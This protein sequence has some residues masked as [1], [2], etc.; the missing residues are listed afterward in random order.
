[1]NFRLF[2]FIP[3]ICVL[4]LPVIHAG[5]Q[6]SQVAYDGQGNPIRINKD[7]ASMKLQHRDR[8]EDSITISYH[9]FDSTRNRLIDSSINDFTKK[10]TQPYYYINLGNFG[11]ASKSLLF[12]PL[13]KAGFDAGFHQYDIY[14][15]TIENTKFFQTTRP[16]TELSYLLGSKAE[17]FVDVIHTQNK[18]SNFNFSFE[19]RFSNSPGTYRTQNAS[20]NNIRFTSHYLTPNKRYEAFLIFISTKNASSENGGLKD[21][22]KLDSLSLNDPYELESRLGL[23]GTLVR[24][25]FNTTVNTGNI[26]QHNTILFRHQYD[27]GQKDSLEVDTITYRFFYP[28]LRIQHTLTINLSDYHFLDQNADSTSYSTYF[29]Y[30]IPSNDTV[31]FEDKWS[32]I[33]NEFSLI[34]FPDKK[35]ASQFAK[36]SGAF[37]NIQG[38]FAD[39]VTHKYYN[40]YLSGEYRNRSR[41]NKWDIEAFGH[42]YLNGLNAG[43]YAAGISLKGQVSKK[44]DFIQ[45]GVQN[46]NRTPS[47]IYNPVT[48]FPIIDKQNF[49]K[50][51]ISKVFANYED[52]KHGWVLSGE[53]FLVSNYTYFDSFFSAKQESTL[54][55]VLHVSAEKKFRL[56]RYFNWYTEVHL[57]QTTGNAPVHLPSFLTRNRI[58]FEGNFY[59]NL[60]LSTGFEVRYYSNY[61]ADNYSPFTGQFFYQDSYT[62]SN[63]PDVNFFFDFRIKSFKLFGRIENLNTINTSQGFAFNKYNFV[64]PQYPYQSIWF[65]LGIWWSFVN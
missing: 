46:V 50:E 47:F 7:S 8:N 52:P 10:V 9:Y 3:F 60:F 13:M 42:L 58:A 62:T 38:T 40:I 2:L 4:F 28:R 64:A 65:R 35:N 16:Y 49:N 56:N 29:N 57:Q 54:F 41:N 55:N 1:M 26:Y 37:E 63:R 6:T 44:K 61:H 15:F 31:N 36:V 51:N 24:D 19:Y 25:P 22:S 59:T 23:A 27:F 43:D 18:K 48:S 21:A 32:D 45:I 34:S 5:A 17:Q 12:N 39:T 14:N 30:T 33:T 20:N 11:T 53:Y